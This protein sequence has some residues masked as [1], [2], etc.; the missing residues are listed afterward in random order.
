MVDII[1][2]I[3]S[4][5]FLIGTFSFLK[6][7]GPQEDGSFMSCHWAGQ[8][9]TGLAIILLVMALILLFIPAPAGKQGV[10]L[11]MVP[12]GILT[13]VVPGGLIHL[14]MM[15]TMRCHAVMKPGARVFGII[16]AVLAIVSVILNARR[17][18]NDK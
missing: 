4:V 13:A 10:A 11:A 17:A 12:T 18:G 8:T 5:I 2:L 6:P 9:L 1:V 14:C 16:I 3:V 7:C 15:E